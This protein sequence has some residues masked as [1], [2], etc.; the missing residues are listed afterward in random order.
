MLIWQHS[1]PE[2]HALVHQLVSAVVICTTYFTIIRMELRNKLPF[3]YNTHTNTH[4]VLLHYG[5]YSIARHSQINE[6]TFSRGK[7]YVFD[8]VLQKSV[9]NEYFCL[10]THGCLQEL[11]NFLFIDGKSLSHRYLYYS[12]L[13]LYLMDY[14]SVIAFSINGYCFNF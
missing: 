13:I 6:L 5:S 8:S 12:L 3:Q 14:A 9:E 2:I 10:C 7:K 11:N 4:P 1:F